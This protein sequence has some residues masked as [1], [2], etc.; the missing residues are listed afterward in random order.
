MSWDRKK[1]LLVAGAVAAAVVVVPLLLVERRSVAQP[2]KGL[3]ATAAQSATSA[4]ALQTYRNLGKAY[5]EQGKYPLA[6]GEFQKV[7]ESGHAIATDYMDIGLAFIQANKLNQ[8]LAALTTAKQM[9][10]KLINID[11]ALGIL[12]KRELRFGPAETEFKKVLAV[13]PDDP[14]SWFNLGSVYFAENKMEPALQ[15][16]E[17]INSMGFARAQNFYVASLFRTFTTLVRLGRRS[18]AMKMLN[19]HQRYSN[20]VPSVSLQGTALENGKYGKILIPSSSPV[21]VAGGA[22]LRPV[23]FRQISSQMGISL[24]GASS[25]EAGSSVEV[26]SA[27]YSL[28]FARKKL[29]P[30]LGP[31]IAMGDYDGDN[32]P[33]LYVVNP[34]GTNQ[35]FHN[36]GNGTF[37][38]VTAKAGVEGPPD[39]VSAAFADYDNSGRLSLFVAGLGGVR[40]Y[41]NN[42]N[43][44]F[45]D[46]TQKAGLK[47]E[48]GELDTR[49]LLFDADNDGLLDLV[50]TSYTDLNSPPHRASFRF[51]NDFPPAQIHFYRNNGNGTFTDVTA[52][53][54]LG[55]VR[56]R[57]RNVLFADFNGDGY[58]DLVFFRDDGPPIFF[59]NLGG[60]KFVNQTAQAGPAFSKSTA[61]GG[62]VADFNHDGKFDL[63]LWTTNGYEVLRN[64][65]HARFTPFPNLPAIKAPAG[66]LAFR[67]LAADINGNSF[68]DLLLVDSTGRLHLL[69]N[70]LGHFHPEP[71]HLPLSSSDGI[72]TLKT[73]W[74]EQPG[75]LDLVGAARDGKF[76]A[77]QKTGPNEHW[78]EV[79]MDGTKSNKGGVG[80]EIELKQGDFYDK[81]LITG[82]PAYVYTGR[83]ARLDVVRATWPTAIVEN[84]L[85]VATDT[86]IEFR[87]SE[88]LASSCPLLYAWNGKRFVY[89]TDILGVGP[90]GELAPDGTRIKPYPREFVRL[91]GTLH[92][93]NRAYDFQVTDEMREVDY[94]DRLG[95]L[96]VDHPA[97]EK[98]FSNEI[99]S[100]TPPPPKLYAVGKEYLPLSAVDGHGRNVLPL[101]SR[102]DHRY[103]HDFPRLR[104]LGMARLHTL[105]LNLGS[106]RNARD[107]SL[108]LTGWVF[109]T[110][111]NGARAMMHD[112]SLPMISPY[113]QVR[114]PQGKWVTVIHDMGLP[115]GTERTM[116]VNLTGKFLSND[117][118]VRIVT[119]LCIYWD[120][121]FFTTNDRVI[122]PSAE[123]PPESA[124][125]RYR[126]FSVATSDPRHIQP[127][128]FEYTS[129]MQQ[130]PW[131]PMRGFYTR[132]GNVEPLLTR[133]DSHLVVMS[134]GDD[135]AVHF[136]AANLPPLKP[137]WVRS[138][139]LDATGY[140][141]DGDPNTAYS[142]TVNQ[143]PFRSMANYPP[144]PADHAPGSRTYREYLRKYETRPSYKLIPPL[145]PPD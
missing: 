16:Y 126:G 23:T 104:I 140:A 17:R 55:S 130:A 105:T 4:G 54:G 128:H 48:L 95:L 116:R 73:A 51:P 113:L 65:G 93:R 56:G 82:G 7:T 38:N 141:K 29:V 84:K 46:V 12:N 69:A 76:L 52:Q 89:V 131:N 61:I 132:Y 6:I 53:S 117:H 120:H 137:G 75:I 60:D 118:H 143:L 114:N 124:N 111:S 97:G 8:A 110:D 86:A 33:D 63:A 20:R 25:P 103:P 3:G 122:Q 49:A 88:R 92:E 112:P 1:W 127:D 145:A 129:L 78:L 57:F 85:N 34:G 108:W 9:A 138:F 19:L 125:L 43:G 71:I 59:E 91:P 62:A 99:Y 27:N 136:S 24:S 50:V 28:D 41:K 81:V 144:G 79:G 31:S 133:A 66:L 96:V 15:A 94:I 13:D 2:G 21:R 135:M 115:S 10:P 18:E 58:P 47:P 5:Y 134:T 45:T 72:A 80:S 64:N 44:T 30:L 37:E 68:V 35:L 36:N 40:L 101:I 107:V 121:I 106:L 123:I 42:G 11:Y 102:V 26:K 98:I 142:A 74:L 70:R 109:W 139:F 22:A 119:N 77:W 32:H 14:A 90:L 100:S 67:G 83:L 39:S 87:E